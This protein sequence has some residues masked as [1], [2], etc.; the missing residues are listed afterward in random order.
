MSKISLFHLSTCQAAHFLLT[1]PTRLKSVGTCDV[2][3]RLAY[4][5]F[6]F[7]KYAN[8]TRSVT[9]LPRNPNDPDMKR[10]YFGY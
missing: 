6:R 3:I 5:K 1:K 4:R 9:S 10:T 2:C 8:A 7:R